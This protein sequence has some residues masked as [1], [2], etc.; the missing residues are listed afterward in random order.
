MAAVAAGGGEA[1]SNFQKGTFEKLNLVWA[2]S[3][4]VPIPARLKPVTPEMLLLIFLAILAIVI[5]TE[6]MTQ[7]RMCEINCQSCR[8][9]WIYKTK[10]WFLSESNQKYP[11]L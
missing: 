4:G 3:S 2:P 1:P 10:R 7:F 6:E 8:F 11:G 5:V 9:I